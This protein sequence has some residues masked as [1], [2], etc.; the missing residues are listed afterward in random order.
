MNSLNET[1]QCLVRL[2]FPVCKASRSVVH[3]D[4][5]RRVRSSGSVWYA[6]D[7]SLSAKPWNHPHD[8]SSAAETCT[9]PTVMQYVFS[10]AGSAKMVLMCRL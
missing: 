7:A 4:V 2:E 5:T 1:R 6:P 8:E 3:D 10:P 9:E